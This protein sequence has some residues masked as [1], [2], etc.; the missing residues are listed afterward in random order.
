MGQPVAILDDFRKGD[1]SFKFLLR[2]LDR[3]RLAVPIKGGH[4]QWVPKYIFIT[5]PYE[6]KAY[7]QYTDAA[8]HQV[9]RE[10]IG[11]LM[12]RITHIVH[13]GVPGAE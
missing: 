12:R 4:V 13:V 11:Q 5:C 6:P 9:E 7:F 10:D 1:C 3:Y 2:L 8:G